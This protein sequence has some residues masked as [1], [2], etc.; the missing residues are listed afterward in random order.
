MKI[1]N[2]ASLL[3]AQEAL[4]DILK[5]K[6]CKSGET[7]VGEIQQRVAEA[8][9][10][11]EPADA[12]KKFSDGFLRAQQQGFIAAGRVNSAA[13]TEIKAT[14]MNCFVQPIEDAIST[15]DKQ[16]PGI[17]DAITYAA[18]TMRRGGGVG[19]DFSPIRPKNAKVNGTASRASGPVSYM[20]VFDKSCQTVESAGARRGAQMGVLRVD[21]PDIMEF[22]EAKRTAGALTN[23]NMSIGVTGAFMES[24]AANGDWELV[25]K[26][27][28]S[29]EVEGAYQREDGLWVYGKVKAEDLFEKV[30]QS[31]YNFA[32]PGVLFLDNINRDNN[33]AYCETIAATNPYVSCGLPDG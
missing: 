2:V 9:A 4:Q 7:S 16:K 26:A 11:V 17:Y 25:H 18:E 6:Y 24:L 30:M 8:L 1:D 27:E 28:P 23:F 21:H 3:P 15:G 32:E 31:T 12:R 20:H 22:I 13:G 5:D 29:A 19:Y 10:M 14:L 33:L